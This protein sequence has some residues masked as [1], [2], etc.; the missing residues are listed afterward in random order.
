MTSETSHPG[1]SH[2]PG[3]VGAI[4]YAFAAGIVIVIIAMLVAIIHE[5]L[6]INLTNILRVHILNPVLFLF[7]L[8]P[9]LFAIVTYYVIKTKQHDLKIFKEEIKKKDVTI[10][11]NASLAKEIGE[12]NYNIIIEPEGDNDVMGKSLLVMRD[13]LLS[14]RT[15]EQ[16]LTWIFEGKNIISNTLR[17]HTRLEELGDN[18]LQNVVDYIDAIQGAIYLYNDHDKKLVSLSTYAYSNKEVLQKEY[19]IGY[20]LIGQCAYQREHIYRTEI[21][22]D[23]FFN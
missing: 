5:K 16:E 18:V 12:G 1:I 6:E 19:K 7:Y 4:I 21:P 23:F 8:I 15:R 22:D 11:R 17:M 20:G 14:N 13:N 3:R 9:A 10:D 2:I